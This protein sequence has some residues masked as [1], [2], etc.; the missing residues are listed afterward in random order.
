MVCTLHTD[1]VSDCYFCMTTTT[2]V[3]AESKHTVQYPNL[4]SG[5]R[6]VPHSTEL[7]VSKLP[8][9]MTLSD[10]ESSDEDVGQA[11]N[12]MDCDPTFAGAY[13]SN[14]P[15]LLTQGDLNDIIRYLNLSKKQAEL[16]GSRLKGWN[17]L[18]QNTKVCFYRGSHEKFKD[19]F[20]LE[21]SVIFCNDVCSNMKVLGHE[22]NPD[23]W[24]LFT[25]LSKVSLKVVLLH[26]GNRLPSVPLAHAA[27][28][29]ES[30][31]SMKL[32]LGKI[33]YDE[34][35]WKLFGDLKVVALLLRMQ[36]G[37]TNYSCFL[38]E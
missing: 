31:E 1:H 2:G 25:D 29:K 36:L 33:K 15:H 22:Y 7:P 11:N 6:P 23:Q 17:L 21:D 8:P 16:L 18:C 5:M 20:S 35:K 30:Y 24:C 38:C 27:N 32:L 26:N 9:N 19:F 13:S 28:M 10:S 37:Y 14:E 34:F 12:N 4:P 3:T